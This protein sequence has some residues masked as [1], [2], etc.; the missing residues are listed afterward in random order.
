LNREYTRITSVWYVGYIYKKKTM[1][2]KKMLDDAK[3]T[4]GR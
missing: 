1:S 3:F 4:S 2:E